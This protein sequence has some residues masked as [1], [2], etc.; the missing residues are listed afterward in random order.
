M[1]NKEPLQFTLTESTNGAVLVKGSTIILQDA[2]LLEGGKYDAEQST[3]RLPSCTMK[4]A[5]EILASA[6]PATTP[7]PSKRIR[8]QPTVRD[9]GVALYGKNFMVYERSPGLVSIFGPVAHI[10]SALR[11][12]KLLKDGVRDE[13]VMR[14]NV[15]DATQLLERIV[16]DYKKSLNVQQ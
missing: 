7:P 1:S 3:W 8:T 10:S 11:E 12:N 6:L 2:L 5:L 14:G 13:W 9:T 16:D 4:H 15:Q